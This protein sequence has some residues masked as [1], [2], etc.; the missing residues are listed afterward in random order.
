MRVVDLS[1][2]IVNWN[3]I[4][5]MCDCLSSIY[6]N[7]ANLEFE[8]IV[9]DNDSEDD[10]TVLQES[11]P[12]VS[13][14]QNSQN[15]GFAAANNQGINEADGRYILL[16][17]P[18]TEVVGSAL[19][20][21][22]S[23]LDA[24]GNAA[25]VG[26]RLVLPDGTI[27]GGAAGYFPSPKTLFNYA[28]ML[29]TLFP[30]RAKGIWLAKRQYQLPV[31]EVDWIAGACIMVR[32]EVI[33]TVGLMDNTFFMYAEDVDWCYRMRQGGWQIYCLAELVVV[34]YI[35][36]SANQRDISFARHNVLGL[37]HFYRKHYSLLDVRWMHLWGGLGFLLRAGL[38]S[39]LGVLR[40]REK[41]W[42]QSRRMLEC[43]WASFDRLRD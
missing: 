21:M 22:V 29:H 26:P 32:R 31:I 33:E 15:V 24:N 34:H 38:Y 41:N 36:G 18:D 12:D 10:L 25:A 43:S 7:C 40:N 3:A 2:V 9:V 30:E 5:L 1:I 20:E 4:D 6:A 42:I 13:I 8:V 37:D 19:Q 11:Y 35:G 16:I 27:Q 17:N 39:I 14:I 28:F 23:F